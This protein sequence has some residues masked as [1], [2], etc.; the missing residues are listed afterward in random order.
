MSTLV[1]SQLVAQAKRKKRF[2]LKIYIAST[3]IGLLLGLSISGFWQGWVNRCTACGKFGYKN[4]H[5][6]SLGAEGLA[7][8]WCQM[9]GVSKYS[10]PSHG[11]RVIFPRSD[12]ISPPPQSDSILS[13]IDDR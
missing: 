4:I 12:P 13:P 11:A 1:G 7:S 5:R 3:L 8:Y 2:R 6:F 9:E 10:L